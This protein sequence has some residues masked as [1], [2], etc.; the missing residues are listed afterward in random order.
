M[1]VYHPCTKVAFTCSRISTAHLPAL[2]NMVREA[3]GTDLVVLVKG[4]LQKFVGVA[5]GSCI[6]KV[7]KAKVTFGKLA[8]A[9]LHEAVKSG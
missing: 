2:D 3:A 9:R 7:A 8:H 6:F 5:V 4:T 1:C